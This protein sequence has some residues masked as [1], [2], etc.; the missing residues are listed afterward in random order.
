MYEAA[1]ALDFETA[2]LL[3]DEIKE[4]QRIELGVR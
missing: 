1:K 3:R 4:L 2:A